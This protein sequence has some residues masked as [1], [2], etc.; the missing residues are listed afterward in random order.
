MQS[1]MQNLSTL[2]DLIY[3]VTQAVIEQIKN[4]QKNY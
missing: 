3:Q 1:A 4:K 2:A